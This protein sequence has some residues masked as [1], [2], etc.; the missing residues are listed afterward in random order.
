MN[1]TLIAAL[2]AASLPAWSQTAPQQV[3]V[4]GNPMGSGDIASPSNVLAGDGLTLRRGSTLGDTLSGL[5]GVATTGFAPNASRP[6]IRG[7]DGDRIRVLDNGGAS[8][9]ASSLSFDHALPIDPL[10]AERIEVLRGPAA[11]LYG[12]SAVGGVINVL[13]NRIPRSPLSGVSGTV[14][15]LGGGAAGERSASALVEAGGGPLALHADAFTRHTTDLRV[16]AFDRPLQGGGSQRRE[17]VLNSAGQSDGGAVG[18]SLAGTQGYV[19]VAADRYRSDYGIVVEDDVTLRMRRDRL[20]AAGEW[21][22]RGGWLSAVRARLARTD[23][24]HQEVEGATEVGTTFDVSGTDGRVEVVHRPVALGAGRLDGTVGLQFESSSFSALGEEAFVP[25]TRTR[26]A[27]VFLLERW[28][29]GESGHL[30][31][32]WRMERVR[33]A[34]AGDAPGEPPRFGAPA[35]RRFAPH[36]ASVGAVW[37]PSR[38][39]Q[40]TSSASWTQRAPTHYE[41]YADGVH[42]ATAAYERGDPAQALERSRHLEAAL[43]W[44]GG[45]VRAQ[46]GAFTSRF[47]NYILLAASGEPDF[48][49]EEGAAYPVYAFRGVPA[50]L[51]GVEAEAHWRI[52]EG[53]RR[54]DLEV[55]LDRV[56]GTDLSTGQPLPR[57]TPQRLTLGLSMGLGP[58]TLGAQAQRAWAQTRVPVGDLPTAGWTRL[59]LTLARQVRWAGAGG[60]LFAQLRNAGDTLSYNAST[61]AT[62][63]VLS[64]LPGRALSVGLRLGM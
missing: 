40:F 64:P 34:S 50:R 54:V 19:G 20:T 49:D 60:L 23:Y 62:A 35:E 56:L 24:T 48:V 16:P 6:I 33:V 39:W 18:A 42:A 61:L 26:Q 7:L 14:Q 59:D 4:T 51:R 37:K 3:V 29:W 55:R 41:L 22:P 43:A 12:G 31:A 45:P 44:R 28:S 32:G 11:L 15:L 27:S 1:R 53:A 36:S 10:V 38:A 2:V 21:R 5:T 13:D 46:L 47:A 30:S 57:M 8:L 17:R 58:W 63:R 25:T 52:A 9:D